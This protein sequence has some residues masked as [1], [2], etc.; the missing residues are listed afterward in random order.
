MTL[1]EIKQL[2]EESWEGCDGCTETDKY[3][4]TK[5]YQAGYN[6]A[7]PLEI[8]EHRFTEKDIRFAYMQGYNRGKD[9]NP[10]NMES[11]IEH[12]NKK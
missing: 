5:G 4:W 9:N 8:S 2:A 1:E 3:F 11:Y 10:N 6:K 12:I 7:K